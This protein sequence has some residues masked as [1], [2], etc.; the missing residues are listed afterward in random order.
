MVNKDFDVVI[1]TN[2]QPDRLTLCDQVTWLT[3]SYGNILPGRLGNMA[4]TVNM[5]DPL[6]PGNMADPLRPDNMASNYD[7]VI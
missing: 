6:R 2:D 5:A 3:F 4:A 7:K 1:N